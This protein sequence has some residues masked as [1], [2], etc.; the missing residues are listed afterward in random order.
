V[1]SKPVDA[2]VSPPKLIP[3]RWKNSINVPGA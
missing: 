2:L 3:I 1:R